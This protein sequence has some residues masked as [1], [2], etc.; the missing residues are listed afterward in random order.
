MND[1]EKDMSGLIVDIRKYL[2]RYSYYKYVF[3]TI[4]IYRDNDKKNI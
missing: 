2:S 4:I 3:T 1:A